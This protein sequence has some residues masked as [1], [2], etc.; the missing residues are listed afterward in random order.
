M[1]LNLRR[2]Q[3]AEQLLN[4]ESFWTQCG[5]LYEACPWATALQSPAFVRSWYAFYKQQY[6]PILIC[7]FSAH[8]DLMG[9]LP[10]A[11]HSASGHTVLAGAHQAEYKS[12]LAL[13]SNSRSFIDGALRLVARET[14]IRALSFRYLSP[15]TPVPERMVT[16]GLSWISELESHPRPFISLTTPSAAADYI[17]QKSNSTVRNSRNRLR[18]MGNLQLDRIQET[19][20]LLPIF[21]ELICWYDTRQGTEHGKKAFQHDPNKKNWHLQLLKDRLLHV[22]IL[23]VGTEIISGVFGM[24]DGKTYTLAM[25]MFCPAYARYS[26]VVV[27]H[28]LLVE[29]LQQEG[30][31]VLDLTP[32]T[33]PFK[34]RFAAGYD[35]VNVLSIYLKRGEWFRAKVREHGLAFAK[36][37]L[38]AFGIAPMSLYQKLERIEILLGLKKA[39]QGAPALPPSQSLRN[40]PG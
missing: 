5:G 23:K 11:R 31:K 26:P 21:D 19:E 2:S 28:L 8:G 4:S 24:S 10:L 14:D 27:H 29:R 7:E 32:G 16:R 39:P 33:D 15:G 25:S 34:E 30:Y 18:K 9:F 35:S 3:E 20:T 13:P 1:P 22:T 36:P 6:E 17:Q 40:P 37:V 12:W 38:S